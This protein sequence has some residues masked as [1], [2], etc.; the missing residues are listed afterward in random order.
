VFFLANV[1]AVWVLLFWIGLQLYQGFAGLGMQHGGGVAY[2]AHI[3]G[4]FAGMLLIT[5]LGG[6]SLAVQQRRDMGPYGR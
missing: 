3:G 6:R 1:R 4:F 5:L 2:F